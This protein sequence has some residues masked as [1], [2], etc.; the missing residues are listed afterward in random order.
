MLSLFLVSALLLA[1]TAVAES[2]IASKLAHLRH[3]VRSTRPLVA[4]APSA[5]TCGIDSYDFSSLMTA[6]WM[7]LSDDYDEIYYVAVCH[8]VQ[9]LWCTLNPNTASVQV[10]QV[11]PDDTD[12]TYALMGN[13]TSSTEWSYINNK[14][15]ADGIQF[16][17]ATGDAS[18]GCPNSSRRVTVG[19]LVCGNSTG[20]VSAIVEGPACTYTLTLPTTQLCGAGQAVDKYDADVARVRETIKRVLAQTA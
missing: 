19:Q 5:P 8:T 3:P 18:P 4:A 2:P 20:V 14:T 10:C 13:D 12:Y 17:S 7:G 1:S 9:N 15:A 11:S 16:R 6:D